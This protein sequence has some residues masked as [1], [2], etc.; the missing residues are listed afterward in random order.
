[1][2]KDWTDEEK[3]LSKE[4]EK[5]VK[6]YTS[7]TFIFTNI[8]L[9]LFLGFAFSVLKQILS[10]ENLLRCDALCINSSFRPTRGKRKVSKKSGK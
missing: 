3:K 1:M 6:G 7:S 10:H 9:A 2:E 5:R 4:Y 8:S